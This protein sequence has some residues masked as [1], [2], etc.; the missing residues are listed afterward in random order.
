MLLL[1]LLFLMKR[2]RGNGGLKLAWVL[3]ALS[4]LSPISTVGIFVFTH[5]SRLLG[6]V[7]SWHG[8]EI[9]HS[10]IEFYRYHSF[11]GAQVP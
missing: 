10:F 6:T 5:G 11:L 8:F 2:L 7:V 1:L 3:I 4:T 9:T